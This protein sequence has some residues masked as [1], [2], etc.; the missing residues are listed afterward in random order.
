MYE[1]APCSCESVF[2]LR[3]YC[4]PLSAI[5]CFALLECILAYI[6]LHIDLHV[7]HDLTI[8]FFSI[9]ITIT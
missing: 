7:N 6:K 2:S 5:T 1:I 8:T 4:L 3:A 9:M